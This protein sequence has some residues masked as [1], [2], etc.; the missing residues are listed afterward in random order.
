M[1][2]LEN[3][4]PP[5]HPYLNNVDDLS[6]DDNMHIDSASDAGKD[7]PDADG[8]ADAD[9]DG[10]YLDEPLQ[11]QSSYAAQPTVSHMDVDYEDEPV[12][13]LLPLPCGLMLTLSAF[14]A[15]LVHF[16]SGLCR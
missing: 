15:P 8:D 11:P 7:D 4:S 1:S 13:T 3:L 2:E 9:G 16:T 10:D 14:C 12:R 5:E 6:S